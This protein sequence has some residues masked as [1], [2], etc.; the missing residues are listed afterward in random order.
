MRRNLLILGG[1]G[2]ISDVVIEPIGTGFEIAAVLV[3]AHG[4]YIV[5]Q[6]TLVCSLDHAAADVILP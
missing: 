4:Q 2:N 5:D 1:A 6:V 3:H